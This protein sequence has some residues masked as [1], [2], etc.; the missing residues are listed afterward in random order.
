MRSADIVNDCEA[1]S[2]SLTGRGAA[3]IEAIEDAIALLGRNTRSVVLDL[4]H[5]VIRVASDANGDDSSAFRISNRV[6]DEVQDELVQQHAVADDGARTVS[7]VEAEIDALLPRSRH[8]FSGCG[9]R[10]RAHV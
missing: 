2:R 1:E 7:G 6:V 4:Q 5:D 10:E 9:A 8:E 3:A